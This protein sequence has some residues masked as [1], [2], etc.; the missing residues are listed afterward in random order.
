M[1]SLKILTLP[2][3]G[4]CV[5]LSPLVH[6]QELHHVT[7]VINVEVPVRVFDGGNLLTT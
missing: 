1:K 2:C 7:G 4:L 5:F 3:L 6:P